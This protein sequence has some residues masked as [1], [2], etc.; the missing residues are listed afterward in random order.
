MCI[1]KSIYGKS[2]DRFNSFYIV[3]CFY[4]KWFIFLLYLFIV[5][6]IVKNGKLCVLEVL[7]FNI[8]INKIRG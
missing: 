3:V 8:K 6:I 4:N 5:N 2:D 7:D 1:V